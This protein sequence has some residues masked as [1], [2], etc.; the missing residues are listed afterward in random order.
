MAS[1]CLRVPSVCSFPTTNPAPSAP[2][3]RPEAE[4]ELAR[5]QSLLHLPS[6]GGF[7][8]PSLLPRKVCRKWGGGVET[9]FSRQQFQAQSRRLAAKIECSQ[10]FEQCTRGCI[11]GYVSNEKDQRGCDTC[12]WSQSSCGAGGRPES[13]SCQSGKRRSMPHSR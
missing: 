9:T 5:T 12:T 6:A 11:L 8:T 10:E 4:A 1:W 3:S 13:L 7:V 2:G